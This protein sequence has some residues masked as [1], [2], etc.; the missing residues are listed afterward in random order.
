MPERNDSKFPQRSS[1]EEKTK[2]DLYQ[3]KDCDTF[4]DDNCSSCGAFRA[5]AGA[6]LPPRP[7]KPCEKATAVC[8]QKTGDRWFGKQHPWTPKT[9]Y[10]SGQKYYFSTNLE[11]KFLKV[12]TE[13][14][15][16]K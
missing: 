15:N 8:V 13:P 5:S 12:F 14:F 1:L 10:V 4:Y 6:T 2:D 7:N 11:I 9:N 3:V 16:E